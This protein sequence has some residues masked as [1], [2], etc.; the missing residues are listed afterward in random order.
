MQIFVKGTQSG[1]KTLTVHENETVQSLKER[2][3]S[4]F[5]VEIERQRL[6]CQA[7]ELQEGYLLS[8]FNV[9]KEST[10]HLSILISGGGALKLFK[11]ND[12]N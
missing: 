12:L 1:T 2:I 4:L 3:S 7:K 8:D 5:G 11:F 9:Q 10:I 6:T